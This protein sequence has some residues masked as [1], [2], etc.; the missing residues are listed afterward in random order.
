MRLEGGRSN[1]LEGYSLNLYDN[2]LS[3]VISGRINNWTWTVSILILEIPE[4]HH[5]DSL[6]KQNLMQITMQSALVNYFHSS[7]NSDALIERSI[8]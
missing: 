5:C 1:P 6:D 4:I 8:L 7:S 3:A 2:L